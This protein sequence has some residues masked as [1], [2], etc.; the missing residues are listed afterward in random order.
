MAKREDLDINYAYQNTVSYSQYSMYSQC[1]YRWYL[2]YV[3]KHKIDRP[4]IHLIFGTAV[5]EVL[6]DYLSVMYNESVRK[7]DEMDLHAHLKERLKE[8]YKE[9]LENNDNTH[10]STSEELTEFYNDGV[11]I[12]DWFKKHRARYFTT[13]NT[14]LIGVEVPMLVPIS[15]E[16]P[17]VFLNAYIDLVM[18][19]KNVDTY[20]IYDIKTSTRGWGD[21]EK[22]DKT[23]IA[24]VLFYKR[25]FSKKLDIPEDKIEVKFLILRRKI[26]ENAEFP[27]HRVQEW[28]PAQ[29]K[30]KVNEAVEELKSFVHTSFDEKSKHIHRDYPKNTQ[31]C[32]YCQFKD[33]P[34]LCQ[35]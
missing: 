27:M 33:L 30:K 23:K 15:E 28:T 21:K 13:K 20:V 8:N 10:F 24:Q 1:Q 35:R 17:N 4:G 18:L 11:A 7:A 5:H 22:R 14:E 25:Y 9:S 16:R 29:G 19:E 26:F 2:A 31:A 32:K 34:N 12:I 3:K 6:Q